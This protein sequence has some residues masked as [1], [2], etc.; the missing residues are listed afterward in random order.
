[1]SR[2][3]STMGLRNAFL[4]RFPLASMDKARVDQEVL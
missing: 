3:D 1:M 2:D 4:K